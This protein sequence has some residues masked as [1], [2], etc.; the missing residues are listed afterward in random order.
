MSFD[1]D[2]KNNRIAFNNQ[3]LY[4]CPDATGFH[5]GGQLKG[6]PNNQFRNLPFHENNGN[7]LRQLHR[8]TAVNYGFRMNRQD[9]NVYGSSF[10]LDSIPIGT[11]TVTFDFEYYL[12]EGYNENVC[13]FVTNGKSQCVSNH[14][15]RHP[16]FGHNFFLLMGPEGYNL[17][18]Q[19][20]DLYQDTLRVVGIG[21][22]FLNQYAVTAEVNAL[23]KARLSYEAFN[24]RS[25]DSIYNNP[26]P[27]I[28]TTALNACPDLNFSIPDG[29]LGK[30]YP[31]LVDLNEV[32]YQNAPRGIAP[33]SIRMYLNDVGVIAQQIKSD[34]QMYRGAAVIQGF[35]IN[36]PLPNTKIQAIGNLYDITRVHNYPAKIEFKITAIL[37]ELK[38]NFKLYEHL[39][40]KDFK[41]VTIT[42]HDPCQVS[43]CENDLQQDDAWL[44][45]TL[46]NV[47]LLSE[48]LSLA[49]GDPHRIVELSFDC[50]VAGPEDNA[51][52]LFIDGKA[53]FPDYPK[54]LA[55]GL[56][57]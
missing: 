18:N 53:F 17:S 47:S 10:R 43:V 40:N 9:I 11:P 52:G 5:F 45:Y 27:S 25:Y 32:Q 38:Q 6:D 13:G 14:I 49:V 4:V 15:I 54:I 3:L 35:T 44:I 39:C 57:L 20:L 50:Q 42:L 46:K 26:V 12:A 24:I 1:P 29:S 31:K 19:N 51:S 8:V 23:P 30:E 48:T 7:Q 56:P 22:C 21:N 28:N 34:G 36:V 2:K 55:W 33:G 37:S 16:N 41:D